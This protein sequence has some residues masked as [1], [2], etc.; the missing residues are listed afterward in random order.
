MALRLKIALRDW[1]WLTPLLLG[2][3]DLAELKRLDVELDVDRVQTLPNLGHSSTYA[4]AEMSLSRYVSSVA[5]G[6]DAVTA[7]P[8]CLMQSFRH[9]CIVVS[10]YSSAHSVRDL[11]GGV[12]GLTGWQDSGNTWTR[13]VLAES[14]VG[15]DDARWVVGRLTAAHPIHDRLGGYGVPG[16]I[17]SDPR[18]R[19]LVELLSAGELDAI[20]TPFMPAGFYAPDSE[21]RPLLPDIAGAEASYA[22]RH[23]FVPGIHVLAFKTDLLATRPEVVAAISAALENSRRI[24]TE[25]RRRYAETSMWLL[26][27]LLRES[28]TLPARWDR[29][30]LEHQGAMFTAFTDQMVTQR[31][32]KQAPPLERLFPLDVSGVAGEV[33]V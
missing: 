5:A 31:L 14:G 18:E 10:R 3:V 4:A 21:W 15:I 13:A 25:K 29:P 23:G 26:G 7:V 33:L 6:R 2:E 20:L 9:R 17:E 32:L 27:D 24:W 28:R 16:R 11:R 30:G 22:D 19:P 8:Q 1:D 12:I